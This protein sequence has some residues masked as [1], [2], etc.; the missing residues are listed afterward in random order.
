MT[1]EVRISVWISEFV[2]ADL[3]LVQEVFVREAESVHASRLADPGSFVRRIARNLL[4]D[5]ARRRGND[6][7]VIFPLDEQRDASVLAEQTL[8]LEAADL[9]R[10]YKQA[11]N[12]LPEKDRKSTRLNSSH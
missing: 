12:D 6:N 9:F 3:D 5:R 7:V 11:V 8:D 1:F 2:S 10:I 4:I